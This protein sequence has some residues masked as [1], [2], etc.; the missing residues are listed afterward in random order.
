VAAAANDKVL[1]LAMIAR[2]LLAPDLNDDGRLEAVFDA[3]PPLP[4]GFSVSLLVE[5][6]QRYVAIVSV[7]RTK[8]T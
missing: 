2:V 4:C 6:A 3:V 1:L 8:P 5:E 7:R